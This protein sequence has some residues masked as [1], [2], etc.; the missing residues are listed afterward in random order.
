MAPA[1]KPN[2]PN[3]TDSPAAAT[4][5]R[6]NVSFRTLIVSYV[7]G[8]NQNQDGRWKNM[9]LLG[10]F[11]L[12]HALFSVGRE[13]KFKDL[14][15]PNAHHRRKIGCFFFFLLRVHL[16]VLRLFVSLLDT[17]KRGRFWG[18][19]D[20]NFFFYSRGGKAN[21]NVGDMPEIG[22]V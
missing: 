12:C 15:R 1:R 17:C 8:T 14:Q 9:E 21:E 19:F 4:L 16:L 18:A 13:A 5:F 6:P 2:W 22:G 7:S 10:W 20:L 11:W 3:S